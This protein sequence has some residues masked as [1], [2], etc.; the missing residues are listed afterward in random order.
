MSYALKDKSALQRNVLC[1][2]HTERQF[3]ERIGELDSDDLREAHSLAEIIESFL[4]RAVGFEKK[5][6]FDLWSKTD[7]G[8][9]GECHTYLEKGSGVVLVRRSNSAESLKNL[10]ANLHSYGCG[11][12][13]VG[14]YFEQLDSRDKRK[15]DG[16]DYWIPGSRFNEQGIVG[17][18]LAKVVWNFLPGDYIF[19]RTRLQ[20]TGDLNQYKTLV[21]GL[22]CAVRGRSVKLI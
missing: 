2:S 8:F 22:E 1:I 6:H 5:Y 15:L 9:Y 3:V 7:S 17:K 16:I 13:R 20:N 14:I 21:D 11:E 12:S 19:G 18:H 10:F 4:I